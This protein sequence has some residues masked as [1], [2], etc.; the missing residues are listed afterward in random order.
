MQSV[1]YLEVVNNLDNWLDDLLVRR[2]SRPDDSLR[3][4]MEYIR[5][6]KKKPKVLLH[7]LQ[8]QSVFKK[9]SN[10]VRLFRSQSRQF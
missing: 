9:T 3:S 8:S 5:T 6:M 1:S 2:L 4:Q 10:Q 7:D